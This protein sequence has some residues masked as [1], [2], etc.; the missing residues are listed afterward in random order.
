MAGLKTYIKYVFHTRCSC[1]PL[2]GGP[3]VSLRI[4]TRT[5]C[6]GCVWRMLPELPLLRSSSNSVSS[7]SSVVH[8][9][10]YVFHNAVHR[11]RPASSL[12]PKLFR[13]LRASY[14]LIGHNLPNGTSATVAIIIFVEAIR[15]V[16][17][18][19]GAKTKRFLLKSK[20]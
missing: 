20:V 19:G 7:S 18:H 9:T 10:E 13:Y 1:L 4:F 11:S 14:A 15:H 16:Q 5:T 2:A 17:R 6:P 3:V 8:L 12:M